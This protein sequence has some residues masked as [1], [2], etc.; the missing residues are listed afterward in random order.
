MTKWQKPPFIVCFVAKE[1]YL[2]NAGSREVYDYQCRDIRL[3]TAEYGS[4]KDEIEEFLNDCPE[5]KMW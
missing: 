3:E 1:H 4:C 5:R 2:C